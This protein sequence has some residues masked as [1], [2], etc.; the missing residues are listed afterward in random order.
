MNQPVRLKSVIWVGPARV[1]LKELP[2][3]AQRSMGIAGG[4]DLQ[5][6]ARSGSGAAQAGTSNPRTPWSGTMM[7]RKHL[8][9]ERNSGNV[10]ADLGFEHPEE[11]LAKA[12]LILQILALIRARGLTQTAAARL[13]GLPQPKVSL[14]FRGQVAGFSTDRLIRFLNR[15]DQDVEIVVRTKPAAQRA[16]GVR[17][18]R[19]GPLLA[20]RR[21]PMSD[22]SAT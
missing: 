15:L 12:Q 14:L 17:V 10:I 22:A 20:R 1:E 3:E 4:R 11:E 5:A 8:S 16:A 19:R 6:R 9:F 21:T 7:Q 18:V 2:R 13:L